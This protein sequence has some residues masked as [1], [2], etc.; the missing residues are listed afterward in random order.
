MD[1]PLYARF[2]KCDLHMQTPMSRFWRDTSSRGSE[3]DSEELI[4]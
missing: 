4:L 2:Y 3:A 1:E